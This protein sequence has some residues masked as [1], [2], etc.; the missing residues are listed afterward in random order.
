MIGRADVVT[1][2]SGGGGRSGSST[3]IHRFT[4][5]AEIAKRR[6]FFLFAIELYNL[7]V[8]MNLLVTSG[9]VVGNDTVVP[10]ALFR[11]FLGPIPYG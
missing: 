7:W 11:V 9:R 2:S 3:E 10:T 5:V 6:L 4:V 8:L 1:R